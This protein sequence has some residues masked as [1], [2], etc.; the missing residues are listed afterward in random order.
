MNYS[1]RTEVVLRHTTAE[2]VACTSA[3]SCPRCACR[4]SSS[5][6]WTR[7]RYELADFVF[8]NVTLAL[9]DLVGPQQGCWEAFRGTGRG[10]ASA[11]FGQACINEPDSPNF[12]WPNPDSLPAEAGFTAVPG[13]QHNCLAF[14]LGH[15][16]E[17]QEVQLL[18]FARR[19]E[20]RGAPLAAVRV[21]LLPR[22]GKTTPPQIYGALPP[23]A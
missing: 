5:W 7:R 18:L 15:W 10:S 20:H 23:H 22:N 13:R 6:A 21:T 9:I 4:C 2:Q 3:C 19:L 12:L 14:A 17:A 16:M 11:G 8:N 1:Y